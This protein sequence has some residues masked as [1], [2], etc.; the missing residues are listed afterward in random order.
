MNDSRFYLIPQPRLVTV[1]EDH[2]PFP[3]PGEACTDARVWAGRLLTAPGQTGLT[4]DPWDLAQWESEHG[5]L[6]DGFDR[7]QGYAIDVHDAD[8][9]VAADT[10]A[11]QFYALQTLA[12]LLSQAKAGHLPAVTIVDWPAMTTRAIHVCYHLTAEWMPVSSP[13]L[14]ALLEIIERSA[15]YKLNAVLLEIEAMF[16]HRRHPTVPCKLAFTDEEIDRIRRACTDNHM[17]IIPLLQCLGHAYHVLRNPEYAHLRETPD[18]I[19]Q[20]CPLNE[21]ARALY[22]ELAEEIADA[23][24]GLRYFHIG[25]DESRRLGECAACRAFVAANGVGALYGRHVGAVAQGIHDRG[26]TPVLWSDMA[27]THPDALSQLP[28]YA[29]MM[30]WNYDIP[31]S[32]RPMAFGEFTR[33][34]ETWAAAGIRFGQCNSTMYHFDDAMRSIGLLAQEARRLGCTKF[35]ATDWMKAV[36]HELSAIGRAWAADESWNGGRPFDEFVAGYGQLNHG[37]NDKRLSQAYGLLGDRL[38]YAEDS[39]VRIVDRLDRYDLSG[40]TMRERIAEYT[41]LQKRPE[42]VS[43]MKTGLARAEQAT[44]IIRAI[45]AGASRGLYELDV[46]ELSALTHAHKAKLGLA[47]DE[48]MPLIKFPAPGDGPSREALAERFSDLIAEHDDLC[49]RT[50]T[51]LAPAMFPEMLERLLAC[52]YEPAAKQWMAYFRAALLKGEAV[53]APLGTDPGPTHN[54]GAAPRGVKP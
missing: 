3:V 40:L 26:L 11:A 52:R 10:D 2:P 37:V 38:P 41:P 6:P 48:A 32:S 25:G 1:R 42:P 15:H 27:E 28:P 34:G 35:V 9:R 44:E 54:Q 21:E 45:K 31:N 16:P 8:V 39:Y 50:K 46:L 13:N 20:Y 23:F 12:Q 47:I 43:R 24:P 22:L 7:E 4:L 49:E 53:H 5:T 17:E 30:Y 19:Q 33:R 36:P 14:P 18:T 51:S 29:E